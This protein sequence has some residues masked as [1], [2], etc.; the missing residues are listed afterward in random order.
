MSLAN[1]ISDSCLEQLFL[2][3]VGAEA[4][5]LLSDSCLAVEAEPDL[6]GFKVANQPYSRASLGEGLQGG[7]TTKLVLEDDDLCIALFRGLK[8]CCGGIFEGEIKGLA[9]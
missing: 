6:V 9:H 8:D 2:S 1:F 4:D 7:S 3:C 5:F